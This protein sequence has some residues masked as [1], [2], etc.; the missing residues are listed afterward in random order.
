VAGNE[1]LVPDPV[2]QPAEVTHI[3]LASSWESICKSRRQSAAPGRSWAALGSGI[4]S[5]ST[6]L[7]CAPMVMVTGVAKRQL[8]DAMRADLGE[9]VEPAETADS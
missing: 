5:Q 9:P 7:R 4:P 8:Y 2:V 6:T 3:I 1:I